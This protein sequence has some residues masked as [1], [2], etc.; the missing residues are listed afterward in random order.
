MKSFGNKDGSTTAIA[1][2]VT[3]SSFYSWS[4]LPTHGRYK[5]APPLTGKRKERTTVTT[6]RSSNALRPLDL[7]PIAVKRIKR[8]KHNQSFKEPRHI[9]TGTNE[10][11]QQQPE[12]HQITRSS[13]SAPL[14]PSLPIAEFVTLKYKNDQT[15]YVMEVLRKS[16]TQLNLRGIGEIDPATGNYNTAASPWSEDQFEMHETKPVPVDILA[17]VMFTLA[18]SFGVFFGY[19][20][21]MVL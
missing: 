2:S 15:T 11:H 20:V 1:H 9:G 19:L 4:S 14:P 10:M 18:S 7:S 17:Q 5:N 21:M 6:T 12:H 16:A 8:I 13:S 3:S